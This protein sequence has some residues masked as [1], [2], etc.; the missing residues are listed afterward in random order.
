MSKIFFDQRWCIQHGIGRF[1]TEL[2]QRLRTTYSLPIL[3]VGLANYPTHPMDPWWLSRFLKSNGATAYISPGFNVPI[4]SPCPVIT[5]IHDLIHVKYAGE[6]QW[7]KSLY[8]RFLQRPVVRRSP[9]TLTVSEFSRREIIEWYGVSEQQVVS[10]GNGI[11]DAFQ[12]DGPE[13]QTQTPYFIYVGNNRPH[14]NVGVL[15]DALSGL[16]NQCDASLLMVT[17]RDA[18]LERMI[19]QRNLTDRIEIISGIDDAELATCYRG[20]VAMVLPSHYEGFGL[21]LVEAM[22]CGCPVIG[23]NVTS[24][25]EVVQDAG[26]LFSPDDS[27]GLAAHMI[28]V[29]RDAAFRNRLIELGRSRTSTISWDRVAEQAFTAIA[30]RLGLA[31]DLHSRDAAAGSHPPPSRMRG[32]RRDSGKRRETRSTWT[33]QARLPMG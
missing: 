1:A 18:E 16:S 12:N 22:A 2:R 27:N 8:Y 14:K 13:R 19:Q 31:E 4:A 21:P 9:M 6:R 33:G 3:D 10:V 17:K 11:S 25:P 30:P 26:L 28:R 32:N 7:L 20:A 15:L 23:S 29:L 24:I 5:T